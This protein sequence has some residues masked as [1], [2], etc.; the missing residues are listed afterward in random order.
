LFFLFDKKSL[1]SLK[2]V[3]KM[4]N[5]LFTAFQKYTIF[6][7]LPEGV[8]RVC[9]RFSINLVI[10]RLCQLSRKK[11]NLYKKYIYLCLLVYL[12]A[13]KVQ[14]RRFFSVGIFSVLDIG[15]ELFFQ[16][17]WFF[18][19]QKTPKSLRRGFL[20]GSKVLYKIWCHK[21]FFQTRS[22]ISF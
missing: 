13:L 7:N 12:F 3:W 2:L 6:Q 19:D 11:Y 21:W 20:E 4:V 17:L 9:L 18:E 22:S 15:Q 10:Y 16:I 8:K 1:E 5:C 14:W